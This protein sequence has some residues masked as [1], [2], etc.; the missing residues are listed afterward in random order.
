MLSL[1]VLCILWVAYCM[2]WIERSNHYIE[3]SPKKGYKSSFTPVFSI[4]TVLD[5]FYLLIFC[6]EKLPTWF[7]SLL[8]VVNVTFNLSIVFRLVAFSPLGDHILTAVTN[9]ASE[10]VS[11]SRYKSLY[12]NFFCVQCRVRTGH[13]KPG[14]SWNLRISFFRTGKDYEPY[15][16]NQK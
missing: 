14:G 1:K 3:W 6:C 2:K 7:S 9:I 4:K 10:T 15:S 5:S 11:W 16:T 12:R 8:F 13:G